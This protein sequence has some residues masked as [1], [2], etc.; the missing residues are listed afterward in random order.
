VVVV[1]A[2][3][4]QGE[5]VGGDVVHG[6]ELIHVTVVQT[7]LLQVVEVLVDVAVPVPVTELMTQVPLVQEQGG[8]AEETQLQVPV[9]LAQL[10]GLL[11]REQLLARVLASVKRLLRLKNQ[12]TMYYFSIIST[13]TILL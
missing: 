2:A 5:P 11:P 13:K 6:S 12:Y 10:H 4:V 8:T 3:V 9:A 1:V 7:Q